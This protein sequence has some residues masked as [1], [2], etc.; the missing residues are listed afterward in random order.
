MNDNC[1]QWELGSVVGVVT[2]LWVGDLAFDTRQRQK[3]FTIPHNIQTGLGT[4][5]PT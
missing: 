4:Y 3:D 5:P 1:S 2:S